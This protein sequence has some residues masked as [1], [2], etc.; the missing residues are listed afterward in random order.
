MLARSCFVASAAVELVET[1]AAV[2]VAGIVGSLVGHSTKS[3]DGSQSPGNTDGVHC[4]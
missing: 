1:G 3:L 2:V 4:C